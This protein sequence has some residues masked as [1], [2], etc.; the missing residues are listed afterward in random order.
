M[1]MPVVLVPGFMLDADLWSDLVDDLAALGPVRHAD[2]SRAASIEE[3]AAD[4][5]EAAPGRF[6]LVGFSMGGYVARAAQRA[7]PHRIRRLVLI[8]TSARGDAAVQAQ[9][10]AAIAEADPASFRG[11][12][13]GSIR[14]SLA[15]DREGDTGLVERIR[16]MSVRLGG[17]TF[18]RQALVR[19][20]G[21]MDLLPAIGC[22]TLV[23]A[24]SRD[25]LRSLDEARELQAGIPGATLRIID[26]GHMIP[27]EAPEELSAALL[28]FLGD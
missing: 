5:L 27:M 24:G 16:A 26:A 4:L 21:D 15:P 6:D 23:V 25:R 13:R 12:S 19:R 3:M 7:A 1:D 2:L 22:P 10:K 20:D 9:R 28:A 18:R 11:L 8:A 14:T 17:E